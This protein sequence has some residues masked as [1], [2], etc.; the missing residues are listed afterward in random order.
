MGRDINL[1]FERKR[2][3]DMPWEAIPFT[4]LFSAALIR[5]PEQTSKIC[6]KFSAYVALSLSFT[7]YKYY[8]GRHSRLFNRLGV[9]YYL[10]DS[11]V[12]PVKGLPDDVSLAVRE[13]YDNEVDYSPSYFT[14]YEYLNLFPS[15]LKGTEPEFRCFNDFLLPLVFLYMFKQPGPTPHNVPYF[16]YNNYRFVYWFDS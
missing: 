10:N 13:C 4:D 14:L 6:N 9:Y 16:D 7:S 8:I 3:V 15:K 1:F 5:A 2:D 12:I 11:Q